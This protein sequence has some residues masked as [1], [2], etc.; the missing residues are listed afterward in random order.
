MTSTC[1]IG[2]T[3]TRSRRLR[4]QFRCHTVEVV[5]TQKKTRLVSTL[6]YSLA[7]LHHISFVYQTAISCEALALDQ[8]VMFEISLR[9]IRPY[10]RNARMIS[11]SAEFRR[12]GAVNRESFFFGRVVE[13]EDKV[14]AIITV[15]NPVV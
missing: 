15:Y 13:L 2:I 10:L 12:I 1:S 8:P 6:R 9:E 5:F 11:T 4:D 3:V 7:D 14:C